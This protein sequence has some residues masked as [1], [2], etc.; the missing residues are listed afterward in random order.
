MKVGSE[1]AARDKSFPVGMFLNNINERGIIT[2]IR[3]PI[4]VEYLRKNSRLI[5]IAVDANPKLRFERAKKRKKLDDQTTFKDF[6]NLE[7]KEII[8]GQMN[9]QKCMDMADYKI[10]NESTLEELKKKTDFI[11]KEQK[12]I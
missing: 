11:L 3:A 6:K 4:N 9:V 5:L 12:L 8:L 7:Q 2:S 10:L 1:L